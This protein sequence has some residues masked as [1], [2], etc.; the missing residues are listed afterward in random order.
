MWLSF[1]SFKLHFF[2]QTTSSLKAAGQR[3]EDTAIHLCLPYHF[4][5]LAGQL[6]MNSLPLFVQY[7]QALSNVFKNWQADHFQRNPSF[8]ENEFLQSQGSKI[9]KRM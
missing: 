3:G 9:M 1:S 6:I 5:L 7:F 4:I 8:P 2:T